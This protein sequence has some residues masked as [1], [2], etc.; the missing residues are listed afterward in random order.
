MTIFRTQ[1]T[2]SFD[3]WSQQTSF[4]IPT[5]VCMNGKAAKLN[6][7][8]ATNAQAHLVSKETNP[9]LSAN[10]VSTVGLTRVR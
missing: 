4:G 3:Q 2:Q 6:V 10:H 9:D 5:L 1:T 8:Y 7:M